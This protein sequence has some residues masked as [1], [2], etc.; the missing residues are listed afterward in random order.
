MTQIETI[1][2]QTIN[3][4]KTLC[5]R[6]KSSVNHDCP[7]LEI[8]ERIEGLNGIPVIVNDKLYHVV[9]NH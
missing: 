6:C 5:A 4:L 3:S 9:F 2:Q 7:V 1:K 8:V